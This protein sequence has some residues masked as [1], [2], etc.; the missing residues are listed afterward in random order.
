MP[1]VDWS[2]VL[3]TVLAPALGGATQ[4]WAQALIALGAVALIL[5][6]PAWKL[7]PR[8]I[9]GL[10]VGL[11]CLVIIS[12]LPAAWFGSMPWRK[13]LL[14]SAGLDL[15]AT[16][17]PQPRLTLENGLL[18]LVSLVWTSFLM[19]RRWTVKRRVL[20]SIYALG[21]VILTALALLF[22]VFDWLPPFWQVY[23]TGFGFFP[24][25]N[26]TA[27]VLALGGILTLALTFH[28][29]LRKRD[30]GYLW[31]TGYVLIGVGLVICGSRAGILL[32]LMGSFLWVLWTGWGKHELKGFSIGASVVLFGLTLFCTFGG[33]TLDRFS[34]AP[35]EV[36]N[37]VLIQSDALRVLK[38]TSWHGTGLGNFAP[39]FTQFRKDYIRQNRA[40][41]P[42]SDWLWLGIEMGWIAPA[43]VLVGFIYWFARNFPKPDEP[44][45]RLRA[46]IGVCLIG[47]VLHGFVDVSGHRMGSVWPALLLLAL[48]RPEIG[49]PADLSAIASAEE[50]ASSRRRGVGAR[51]GAMGRGGTRPYHLLYRLAAIPIGAAALWWLVSLLPLQVP[52]TSASIRRLKGQIKAGESFRADAQVIR[53]ATQGAEFAPLDWEFYFSRAIAEARS[54][55]DAIPAATDFR[56]AKHLEPNVADLPFIEGLAWMERQPRLTFGAWREALRRIAIA[57]RNDPVLVTE[58]TKAL[59]DRMLSLTPPVDAF[60]DEVRTLALD[61]RD[62]MLVY[63]KYAGDE[64]FRIEL[65]RILMEDPEL[66]SL[67]RQQRATLFDLWGKKGDAQNLAQKVAAHPDWV[68]SGWFWV[69]ANHA[70]QEDYRTACEMAQRYATNP[71][72]PKIAGSTRPLVELRTTF[73]LLTND[74]T[75]GYALYTAEMDAGQTNDAL[76]VLQHV[77]AQR[78]CPSYFHFLEAEQWTR[79]ER[80]Q[81]AWEAWLRYLR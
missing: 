50:E 1:W 71:L 52:L 77:T 11:I 38:D 37:R 43:L 44:D 30:M 56:R 65:A 78:S 41:H 12:F 32:Y 72:L 48:L 59:Y 17:T 6:A 63:M 80:W 60:R 31:A 49:L 18:L 62:L 25:R 55:D 24:N 74:V 45:F 47:F 19:S 23:M 8:I 5:I 67:D 61:D 73:L 15:P 57:G 9:T 69:A 40:V 39:V 70:S 21:I 26:Q 53:D 58:Q 16:L 29:F 42:E 14:P 68:D 33:K 22:F 51:S 3:L 35:I 28:E 34:K 75:T 13:A 10:L 64:E 54:M 46:A 20:L 66:K 79:R 76:T 36:V 2:I 81:E 4:L 27:N 7:P